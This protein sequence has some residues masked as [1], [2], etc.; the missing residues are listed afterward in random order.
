MTGDSIDLTETPQW[1]ETEAGCVA[2]WQESRNIENN[3]D[4]REKWLKREQA[5]ADEKWPN[6]N[7]VPQSAESGIP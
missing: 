4:A 2:E 7:D 3:P 1:R 5:L 6:M